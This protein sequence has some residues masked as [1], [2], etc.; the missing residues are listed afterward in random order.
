MKMHLPAIAITALLSTTAFAQTT[1]P[2]ATPAPNTTEKP[3]TPMAPSTTMPQ[4]TMDAKPLVLTEAEAK[5][6]IDKVVISSDGTKIGEVAA[7]ARDTSGKVTEM[8][9]DIGG[10]LGMGETRIRLM[11][12]QFRLVDN[13]V[14]LTVTAEQARTLP[15]IPK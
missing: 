14:M 8:H 1:P 12:P 5:T 3:M 13:Q 15:K 10:F 6:W 4:S 7:F 11:P 2:A 9:A